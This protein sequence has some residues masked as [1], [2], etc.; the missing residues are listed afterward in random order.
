M[1]NDKYYCPVCGKSMRVQTQKA[2]RGDI[3]MIDCIDRKCELAYKTTT[4]SE[5]CNGK[6]VRDWQYIPV[7]D[8]LTGE[9]LK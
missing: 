1:H 4:P 2:P 9:K 8:Y 7:Y 3:T 6:Y 5:I